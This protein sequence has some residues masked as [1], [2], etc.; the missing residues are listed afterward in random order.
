MSHLGQELVCGGE[1]GHM[2]QWLVGGGEVGHL[3][4]GQVSGGEVCWFVLGN[5]GRASRSLAVGLCS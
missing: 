2:G 5:L 3:G 1:V 4:H